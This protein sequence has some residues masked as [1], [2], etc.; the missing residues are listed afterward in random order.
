MEPIEILRREHRMVQR[1]ATA[2]RR[3]LD[4]AE[5]TDVVASD[6]LER[7]LEFFRYFTNSCHGPKEEDL[8]FTALH[9]RGLAWDDD[10]LRELVREHEAMR[11]ALDSA[12]DWVLLERAGDVSAARPLA[13]DLRIYLDLLERHIAAEEGTLFPLARELLTQGDLK[14]LAEAFDAIACEELELGD[15]AYYADV[16][17][18]LAST[19]TRAA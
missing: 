14:Q 18:E 10:P 4:C 8:L 5:E 9:H 12:S 19:T 15:R 17:R 7:S 2:T 13:H 6:R 16:A 11:V 3:D 1:V